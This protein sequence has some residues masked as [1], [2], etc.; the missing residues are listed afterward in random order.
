MCYPLDIKDTTLEK[1]ATTKSKKM[2]QN[3]LERFL[4]HDLVLPTR[5]VKIHTKTLV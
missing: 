2:Q 1:L 3:C 4:R 5:K